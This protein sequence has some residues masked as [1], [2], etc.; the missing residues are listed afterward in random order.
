M[1]LEMDSDGPKT[2]EV[3]ILDINRR[4]FE[5]DLKLRMLVQTIGI[6]AIAAVG[7]PTTRLDVG[8][9]IGI[10]AKDTEKGFRMHRAGADLDVVRLLEDAA[11]LYPKLGEL[12]DQILEVESPLSFLKFY[13]SFQVCSKSSRVIRRRSILCSIQVKEA[14]RNSPA[15]GR[16]DFSKSMRSSR[17]PVKRSARS[18]ASR[19]SGFIPERRHFSQK[20]PG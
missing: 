16:I 9:A 17:S 20:R 19:C 4:R 18:R 2:L 6:F 11:L 7:G 8:D 14:S 1:F 3:E 5:D 10:G 13:F 12:Q 15:M